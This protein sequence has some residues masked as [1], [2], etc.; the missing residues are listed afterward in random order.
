M[1]ISRYRIRW[2]YS[3]TH[4]HKRTNTKT[5]QNAQNTTTIFFTTTTILKPWCHWST[6][7]VLF[8]T[9]F[10]QRQCWWWWSFEIPG[11]QRSAASQWWWWWWSFEVRSRAHSGGRPHNRTTF[12]AAAAALGRDEDEE[13]DFVKTCLII[14]VEGHKSESMVVANY[15]GI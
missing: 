11:T 9:L 4:L 13:Q 14:R 2:K 8:L 7:R 12:R 1:E 3:N 5:T 10:F 6:I 15:I